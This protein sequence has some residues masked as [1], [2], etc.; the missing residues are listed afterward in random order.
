MKLD[1]IK[2]GIAFGTVWAF[3]ILCIA[4]APYFGLWDKAYLL[5]TKLY[6]GFDNTSLLGILVGLVW[7]YADAF[8]GAFLVAFIY[9]K[10]LKE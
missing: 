7:A 1:S 10:L 6:I 4:I 5:T 9:N 3:G 8:I 2:L